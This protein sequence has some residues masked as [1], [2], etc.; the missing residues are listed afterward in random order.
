MLPEYEQN[1]S[2]KVNL[3]K[4][5]ANIVLPKRYANMFEWFLHAGG[6][7]HVKEKQKF[8]HRLWF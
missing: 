4:Y 8:N 1:Y 2:I 5:T 7:E 3:V 6:G